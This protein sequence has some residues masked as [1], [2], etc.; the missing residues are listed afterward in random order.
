MKASICSEVNCYN[1]IDKSVFCWFHYL[2]NFKMKRKPEP[3]NQRNQI[4]RI[5]KEETEDDRI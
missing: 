4:H 1:S 5:E 2:S 3:K